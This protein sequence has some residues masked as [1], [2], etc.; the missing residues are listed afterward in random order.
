MKKKFFYLI[1]SFFTLLIY[2]FILI[3]IIKLVKGSGPEMV[4]TALQEKEVFQ[5][6]FLTFKAALVA[7][8]IILF[9]GVPAAYFLARRDFPGKT[10]IEG[11]IDLPVIIPHPAAGIALLT[12]FG[13]RYFLGKVFKELGIEFVGTFAGIV[14]AMMFVSMPFLVNEV[15]E[16]FRAIDVKLEKVA[17][18]LGASPA[19]VFFRIALPLNKNHIISGFIM[20]WA[21]GI[22]EYGAIVIL[23]YHPMTA[24][25]LLVER[26]TSLGL[27]Y[28]LPVAA[29]MVLVS[30]F[31]FVLLRL[32]T[33][34]GE[35]DEI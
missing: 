32:I 25:V 1:V 5:S 20:M 7:S 23:V 8:L 2:A 9:A 27:K 3:P 4:I 15:K 24:P 34:K 18:T 21:R 26:F 6:I 33:G 16:G 13:Q 11:L 14:L 17:R 12:V 19:R 28:A 31:V 35:R 29:L 10:L 30:L 22:S